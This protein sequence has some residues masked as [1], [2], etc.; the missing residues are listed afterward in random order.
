[1]NN[2]EQ[3][4]SQPITDASPPSADLLPRLEHLFRLYRTQDPGDRFLFELVRRYRL[5]EQK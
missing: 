3:Q 2:N 5:V 1:M 4:P